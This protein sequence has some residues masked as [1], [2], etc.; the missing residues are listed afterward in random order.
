MR[1]AERSLVANE[2]R[3]NLHRVTSVC[4]KPSIDQYE[5]SVVVLGE[6]GRVR[7]AD[8]CVVFGRSTPVTPV[9]SVTL[10]L[11][12]SQE[13]WRKEWEELGE[14]GRRWEGQTPVMDER[15]WQTPRA[16]ISDPPPERRARPGGQ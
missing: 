12:V 1:P 8:Y 9:T 11:I 5:G 2:Q 7:D 13:A 6:G 10:P 15:R 14:E 16:V 3:R 4:V